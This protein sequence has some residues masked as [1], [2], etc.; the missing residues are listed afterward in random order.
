MSKHTSPAAA[1]SPYRTWMRL[2]LGIG[3]AASLA[4]VV[5]ATWIPWLAWIAVAVAVAGGILATWSVVLAK[6]ALQER[7]ADE[8]QEER[9]EHRENLRA[10]HAGQREVLVAID[11][12][13]RALRQDLAQVRSELGLSQMETSRLK[14]DLQALRGKNA[15]LQEQLML[16]RLTSNEGAEV[17]S[18][19]RRGAVAGGKPEWSVG[20]APTIVN[21]DLQRQPTLDLEVFPHSQAN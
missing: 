20:D 8:A 17:L 6:R 7:L 3:V 1:D 18:L 14:G 2:S 5:A 19:P 11:V 4:L 21:L 13:T 16:L 9:Q 15:T 10:A 12:Q